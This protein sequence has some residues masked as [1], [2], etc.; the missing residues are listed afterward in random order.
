MSRAS[1]GRPKARVLPE[2]VSARPSMSRPASASGRVRAWIGN[3]VSMP[4]RCEAGEQA[5]RQP[6]GGEVGR[7]GGRVE[8][9][10]QRLL[11]LADR[12]RAG[13]AARP[14]GAVGTAG[15][16]RSARRV[17]GTSAGAVPAGAGA[18]GRPECRRTRRAGRRKPAESVEPYRPESAG[19][20]VS[21]V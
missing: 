11:K 13:L 10:G 19:R 6:Q 5:L 16:R 14:G 1:I 17:A 7:A 15:A 20:P 12:G 4:R 9:R 2:P 18:G 8:G 3:G 21:E